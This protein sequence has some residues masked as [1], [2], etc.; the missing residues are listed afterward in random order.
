MEAREQEN[1][2][3]SAR[4]G[5]L[6]PMPEQWVARPRLLPPEKELFL[7]FLRFQQFCGGDPRPPD[8]RAWFEMRSVPTAEQAWLAVVFAAMAGAMR[9]KHDDG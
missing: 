3:R 4:G 9:E 7:E 6:L 2:A 5:K 8:A 1:A